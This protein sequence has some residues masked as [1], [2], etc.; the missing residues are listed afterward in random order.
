M[1]A[2]NRNIFF[3]SLIACTCAFHLIA[4]F[5]GSIPLLSSYFDDV[6]IIPLMAG[7]ALRLQ[8]RL[9]GPLHFTFKPYITV[10]LWCYMVLVFECWL[11]FIN[12]A[13]TADM[14]D[15]IAYA[16]GAVLFYYIDNKPGLATIAQ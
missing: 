6:V 9:F 1:K 16:A 4:F 14:G 12:T 11:P 10:L 7:V 5:A 2:L 8:Q 13:Y 3:F 15:G